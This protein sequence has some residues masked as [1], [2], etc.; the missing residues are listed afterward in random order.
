MP[1]SKPPVARDDFLP[2]GDGIIYYDEGPGDIDGGVLRNDKNVDDVPFSIIEVGKN[3]EPG[4]PVKG[5]NGGIFNID[6]DGKVDFDANGDFDDLAEGGLRQTSVTY[7]LGF[8]GTAAA[9]DLVLMQDLSGSFFDDLENV[10]AQFPEVMRTLQ[11]DYDAAFGVASYVDK[12]FGS[13]G[14][15][16][17]YAYRTELA[18]TESRRAVVDALDNLE[19]LSGGDSPESQLEALLHLAKRADSGQIG[20]RE[21][22]QR[23]V[24]LTTD[25]TYHQEGDFEFLDGKPVRNNDGDRTIETED[26]PSVEQ[27]AEA[28]RA[29]NI[30]P[31]F[32]VA[33]FVLP[34]YE[35]LVEM[36][37][38]GIAVELT[39]DSSN[40][41]E[42][43][44]SGLEG[45]GG[46]STAT[47]TVTVGEPGANVAPVLSLDPLTRTD[48]NGK[49]V[50]TGTAK[51]ANFAETLDLVI[52]WGDGSGKQTVSV[53]TNGDGDETFRVEHVFSDDQPGRKPDSFTI[54]AT[55]R[56]D[57]GASDSKTAVAL[58][59]NLDPVLGGETR[60]DVPD[61]GISLSRRLSY[62]G[63]FEDAGPDDTHTVTIKWGDG[64]ISRS[65]DKRG[66]DELT[67]DGGKGSF[68]ASHVYKTGGI[69]E[70]AT[71]LKDDDGGRDGMRDKVYITGMR[72]APEGELQIVSD[73]RAAHVL[74]HS[75]TGA[76]PEGE[77]LAPAGSNL[78]RVETS[79]FR[80]SDET[81]VKTAVDDVVF[82]GSDSQ[83]VVLVQGAIGAAALLEGRGG[84]DDMRGGEMGDLIKGNNGADHLYGQNGDDTVKGGLGND[85]VFGDF[86]S[87]GGVGDDLLMGNR[88]K[89]TVLGGGG[90]D[91]VEGN[92]G[93]DWV[94]GGFGDDVVL[95]GPGN[96]VLFGDHDRFET[97]REDTSGTT[98]P[99]RF[100]PGGD[101]PM[102]VTRLQDGDDALDGGDGN[103]LIFGQGGNDTITGGA[104]NDT[105]AGGQGNDR[106]TL[107]EGRDLV[108]FGDGDGKD[109]ITDFEAAGAVD[110][111]DLTR[112]DR[113]AIADA[114]DVL[115]RA[116]QDGD[117]VV[118]N[119]GGGDQLR[120]LDTALTDLSQ[121]DFLV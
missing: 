97:P 101:K 109:V 69:Y 68:L 113:A 114:G 23:L 110:L 96:D 39:T 47:V 85:R 89:D 93:R 87:A 16:D 59:D 49:V 18:V 79:F 80:G 91:Q 74:I 99:P 26:Y 119:L 8:E 111:V 41:A 108:L 28:L 3:G 34:D 9:F 7:T 86:D 58:V 75:A 6:E 32:A 45:V 40:L 38:F 73:D 70:V 20:F 67:S 53:R 30:T 2:F 112:L 15:G 21:G 60:A 25:A 22:T 71:V 35:A 31:I 37:G 84:G 95:G 19:V 43:I 54:K 64:T 105:V 83:D 77:G 14:S 52:D 120:L 117:D 94:A 1:A 62:T 27:V 88:G 11:A 50:L 5:S 106:L 118:I 78:I 57:D 121:G 17:D 10:N 24:V 82:R 55:L 104:G 65:D 42:A 29:A 63:V 36:L 103:D 76:E 100:V 13:F 48:E 107:G 46:E 98:A 44:V 4:A 102:A 61:S 92:Q 81:F 12:P 116:R 56:D 72:L 33:D 66:L 115:D 51:D 90:D